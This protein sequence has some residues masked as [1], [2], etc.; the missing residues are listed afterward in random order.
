MKG[1]ELEQT[2]KEDPAKRIAALEEKLE[3]L[4]E[5][6]HH[7]FSLLKQVSHSF[8]ANMTVYQD[9]GMPCVTSGWI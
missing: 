8:R 4:T 6:K 9:Q 3:K 2:Q 5:Q 1:T 7:L